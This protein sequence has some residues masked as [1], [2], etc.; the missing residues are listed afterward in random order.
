MKLRVHGLLRLGD[1]FHGALRVRKN[2]FRQ[3]K[4]CSYWESCLYGIEH[5]I[6][7][8]SQVALRNSQSP[9]VAPNGSEGPERSLTAAQYSVAKYAAM[10]FPASI[11]VTGERRRHRFSGI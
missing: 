9:C 2:E 8:K 10:L 6:R 4:F 11:A 7:R 1:F 3:L 5:K